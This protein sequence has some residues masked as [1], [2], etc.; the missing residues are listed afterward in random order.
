MDIYADGEKQLLFSKHY[1]IW[2][3]IKLY[4]QSENKFFAYSMTVVILSLTIALVGLSVIFTYWYNFFYNSLQAYNLK[5]TMNAIWYFI[6]LAVISVL[7]QVYRYYLT[8]LFAIRWRRWLTD[9]LLVRWLAHRSYYYLETFDN[10]TDNPD[11]RVQE[12]VNDLVNTTI[13]LVVGLVSAL[14]TFPAFIVMLWGLSG[15]LRIPMGSW[16]ILIIPGYLVW[17]SLLYNIIGTLFTFWLGKPLI[18]LNFEQQRREASFRYGAIDL[19]NHAEHVALYRAEDHQR[20]ILDRLFHRVLNNQYA[21]ILRQK[22]LLWFTAS[23]D[24]TAV[25]LPLLAALPNY[26]NKV[27]LLG[28]LMQT[29]KAFG[30]VQDSL[31]YLISSYTTIAQWRAIARRL[32]TFINHL[33]EIENKTQKAD[34]LKVDVSKDDAITV[35]NITVSKPDGEVL[36]KNINQTF[37]PKKY[38]LLKG[39]SGIGKSTFVRA[40]A[41]I[42]PFVSGK[43][44]MPIINNMMFV[45][46]KPYMPLGSLK[47]ALLFPNK[48][49]GKDVDLADILT[50]CHLEHLIP[51]LNEVAAWTD[52]LSPGEQQRIALARILIQKPAWIFLDESTSMLDLKNEK[53]FYKIVKEKLPY[54]T[55][56]SVGHRPSLEEYHDE[57]IDAQAYA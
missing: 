31:S 47:E 1:S 2:Q 57:I 48:T 53:Y 26:F 30:S 45:P 3:L 22:K 44:A 46:Q 33:D 21:I 39:P 40:I 13:N 19:R 15:V 51:R 23:F 7:I 8:Q 38:Y 25:L 50:L 24:Q 14:T 49:M 4:W 55:I 41:G 18:V 36:L 54:A 16:G 6:G 20:T 42:W 52:Q 29:L 11:Q 35:K 27:F 56:I 5:D 34:H 37:L 9:Q 10:R 32:T 43:V 12:D 17:I 28:G